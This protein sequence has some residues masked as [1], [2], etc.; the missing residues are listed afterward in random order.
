M[1]SATDRDGTVYEVTVSDTGFA[2]AKFSVTATL[3]F[4]SGVHPLGEPEFFNSLHVA[5]EAAGR[6]LLAYS[7]RMRLDVA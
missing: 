7:G 3:D 1:T 5:R 4:G 2:A 6:R